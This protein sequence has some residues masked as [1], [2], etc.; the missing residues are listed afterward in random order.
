MQAKMFMKKLYLVFIV[1]FLM[2]VSGCSSANQG[3]LGMNT[4]DINAKQT[5]VYVKGSGQQTVLLLSGFATVNP[6]DDFM[7]LID[8]LSEDFTVVTIEY[9]GYGESD[10][11]YAKRTNKAIVE[12]IRATLNELN[13]KPPYVLMPHSMSGLYSLYYANNYPSEVK[14]IVGIDASLPQKQLERWTKESFEHEKL[15]ENYNGLNISITNQWN[16]FYDN[17]KKLKDTKYPEDLPV[18]LFLSSEQVNSV[19]NM[20]N[21][22]EMQTSWVDINKNVITNHNIQKIEV[23]NASHY[24]HHDQLQKISQMS[25]NFILKYA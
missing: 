13:I 19:D 22:N 16:E 9:P 12:E 8:K 18:L 24:M 4:I 20:I 21:L 14:A 10:V 11:T 17:S 2:C 25:K 7:P 3:N 6:I 5:R 15:S 23:L 1:I